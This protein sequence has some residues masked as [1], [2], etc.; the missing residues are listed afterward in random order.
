[1]RGVS[2]A[3]YIE[4][5]LI[6]ERRRH[7]LSAAETPRGHLAEMDAAGID[8]AVMLPTFAALLVYDDEAP[9]DR[10]EEYARA[11]NRWLADFCSLAPQRLIG[12]ALIS[13]HDPDAM[14][15]ELED[16][17]ERGLGAVVLRPNPVKGRLIA[18]PAYASFWAACDDHAIAVLIHEGTHS[19]VPTA[20]A[21]R[22]ETHFGQHACAHPMEAMMAFLALVEGGVLD[23]HP[24]LRVGFLESGC[25][26]LP[27]WLWRLD[28]IFAQHSAE[29][30]GKA[31]RPPS[32]YFRHQ[33][34]IAMEPEEAM[35][36]PSA[37]HIGAERVVFGSDFPHLDHGAAIVDALFARRAALGDD[38]FRQILWDSPARLM[39][40]SAL[41]ETR[42]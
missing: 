28:D 37:T 14:V 21:D 5:A 36:A 7:L 1:M 11:Y 12:A 4:V 10:A 33:C 19:R 20:G 17:L 32:E 18:D 26:W 15:G 25:G 16:A 6:A 9:A 2:E 38:A 3:T 30:R 22:F 34:W 29:L 35:L 24:G 40:L 31:R 13:R 41:R 27:Y 39:G 23:A 42:A 8:V